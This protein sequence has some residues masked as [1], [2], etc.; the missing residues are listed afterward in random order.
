MV[1]D[2]V[3]IRTATGFDD[4]TLVPGT[5]PYGTTRKLQLVSPWSASI[6]KAGPF[7]LPVPQLGFGGVAV[8]NLEITPAPEP[9]TVAMVGLGALGVAGLARLRRRSA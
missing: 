6:R 2:F 9:G 8:L 7:G 5:A 4:K 1:G 3:T